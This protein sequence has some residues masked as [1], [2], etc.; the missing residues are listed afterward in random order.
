M[1]KKIFPILWGINV[2]FL[3]LAILLAS[4]EKL[5]SILSLCSMFL[6]FVMP[7]LLILFQAWTKCVNDTVLMKKEDFLYSPNLGIVLLIVLIGINSTLSIEKIARAEMLTIMLVFAATEIMLCFVLCQDI[8][9]SRRMYI[10]SQVA[11]YVL[12]FLF[13]I[14]SVIMTYDWGLI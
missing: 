12:L 13:I 7:F 5:Y 1:L 4:V 11:T 9:V 14:C 3:L 8:K 6:M 2:V 10:W